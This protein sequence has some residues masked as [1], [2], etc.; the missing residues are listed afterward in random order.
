MELLG[1]PTAV[2]PPSLDAANLLG[3][4]SHPIVT[5]P[6]TDKPVDELARSLLNL[7]D[8]LFAI[9][10][11]QYRLLAIFTWGKVTP[12]ASSPRVLSR[13]S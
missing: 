7:S 1:A 8:P 3:R 2:A 12:N 5:P 9:E 10:L 13:M 11:Q 4:S 6:Q